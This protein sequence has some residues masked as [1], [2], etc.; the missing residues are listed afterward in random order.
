MVRY[1]EKLKN[2][3]N[4]RADSKFRYSEKGHTTFTHLPLFILHILVT[5]N[6]KWKMV[7]IFVDFS[8]YLDFKISN[9]DPEPNDK[10]LEKHLNL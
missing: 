8:E 4:R 9:L 5:S 6:W 1:I 7:Q 10:Y 3:E 2:V